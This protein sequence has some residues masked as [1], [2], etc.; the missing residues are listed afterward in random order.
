MIARSR[1]RRK[2]LGDTCD[3]RGAAISFRWIGCRRRPFIDLED[4]RDVRLLGSSCRNCAA[5]RFDA[6]CH[7]RTHLDA[8]H[9][10]AC[11][12]RAHLATGPRQRNCCDPSRTSRFPSTDDG[13]SV[14]RVGLLCAFEIDDADPSE[15]S[16]NFID[17][18]AALSTAGQT[19]C[20]YSCESDLTHGPDPIRQGAL[21][22]LS[23]RKSRKTRTFGNRWRPDRYMA[24]SGIG[25]E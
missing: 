7:V 13:L 8:D 21:P 4:G 9:Q 23:M 12:F 19:E 20:V 11:A 24:D 15:T 1:H 22:N 5:Q 6:S 3:C 14:Y 10:T 17:C 18:G 16:G 2:P 25:S